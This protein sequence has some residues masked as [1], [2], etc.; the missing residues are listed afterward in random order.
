[1][2]LEGRSGFQEA[3]ALWDVRLPGL[4]TEAA[5]GPWRGVLVVS[6]SWRTAPGSAHPAP[7]L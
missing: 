7:I 4:G 1:M 2:V 6:S 3:L 5:A